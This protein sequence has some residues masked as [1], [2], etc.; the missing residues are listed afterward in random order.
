VIGQAQYDDAA[1]PALPSAADSANAVAA[2]LADRYRVPP[3]QLVRIA[4]G[5]R[6]QIEQSLATLLPKAT[7]DSQ[8]ICYYIGH[9]IVEPAAGPLLLPKEFDSKRASNTGL[10]LRAFIKSL[11]QSPAREK[12][13]LLDTCHTLPGIDA[14]LEPSTAEL[15]EAVKE[16][17]TRPV[18]TNVLVIAS[19]GRDQRGQAGA[20]GEP[21][22]FG[23][24]VAAAFAG[25]A[26]DNRDGR[27]AVAEL[28][29]FLPKGLS[30]R[31]TATTHG[32]SPRGGHRYAAE[33]PRSALRRLHAGRLHRAS[34][35]SAERARSA[36]GLLARLNE[37]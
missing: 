13:L 35:T 34:G 31:Q 22:R 18:S 32:R 27:V 30:E 8:L 36:D 14:K 3:E 15:A 2:A 12:I 7:A 9:G 11:E 4:N 29:A 1:W 17:P 26:D 6:L 24:T 28:L 5:S 16:R 23:A 19:C 10:D 21:S 33:S 25:A 37:A 20:E